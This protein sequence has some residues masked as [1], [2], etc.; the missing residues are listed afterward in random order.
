MVGD[1]LLPLE[2]D[3][4]GLDVGSPSK[5]KKPDPTDLQIFRRYLINP[6]SF[7]IFFLARSGE[8]SPDL[9]EILAS[10]VEMDLVRSQRILADFHRFLAGFSLFSK[11]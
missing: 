6:T 10:F 5:S 9:V 11:S 8:I 3:F 2:P 1:G 4:D 7:E